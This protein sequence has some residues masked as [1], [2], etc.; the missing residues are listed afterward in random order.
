MATLDPP[1]LP[2]EDG[3]N[4]AAKE[5][6]LDILKLLSSPKGMTSGRSVASLD[7]PI[8]PNVDGANLAARNNRLEVLE[9][10]KK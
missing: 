9:W 2:D 1:L 7:R 5:G 4:K 6:R 10:M 3:A 8:L